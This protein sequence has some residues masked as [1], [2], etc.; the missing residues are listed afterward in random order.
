MLQANTDLF[1]GLTTLLPPS[2]FFSTPRLPK[3]KMPLGNLWIK[4]CDAVHHGHFGYKYHYL[5]EIS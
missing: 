1:P 5:W 3:E 4:L 2:F